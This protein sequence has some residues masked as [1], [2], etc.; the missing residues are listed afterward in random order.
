MK[1][2]FNPAKSRAN[3]VEHG[4]DFPSAQ[5]L[6]ADE[7]R[8]VVPLNFVAEPRWLLVSR[9][10]GKIWTAVFTVRGESI[11]LISVR[12]ARE[13]ERE[14]YEDQEKDDNSGGV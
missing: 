1:F 10:T 14:N 7:Q 12:R 4:I 9:L 13:S 8:L 5:E 11:R 2:E 3:A 6:W